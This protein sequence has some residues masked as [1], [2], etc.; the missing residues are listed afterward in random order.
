MEFL[1]LVILI[2]AL[3]LAYRYLLAPRAEVTDQ[4]QAL[5]GERLTVLEELLNDQSVPQG[6]FLMA[7]MMHDA[8]LA[9]EPPNADNPSQSVPLR[10]NDGSGDCL[11]VAAGARA[12]D[13]FSAAV[14]HSHPSPFTHVAR[15]PIFPF[16]LERFQD[17][18]IRLIGRS[19]T[20][21]GFITVLIGADVLADV[22]ATAAQLANE[23]QA[24]G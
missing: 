9:L 2:S 11:L 24:K 18:S 13:L 21:D 3:P 5:H 12:A 4:T 20:G 1:L 19:S 10:L 15:L 17:V 16:V 7:L 8:L 6:Q 23:S 22:R 14:S